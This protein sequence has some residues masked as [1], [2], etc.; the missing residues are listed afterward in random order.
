MKAIVY[1]KYGPP[2]VLQEREVQKPVLK[3]NEV[4]IRNH[5]ATVTLYDCWLRRGTG[6]PGFGLISRIDSGFR[7]PKQPVLGTEFAGEVDAVGA[8]VTQFKPGDAVFG[9]TGI[10]LGAYAEL[11]TM[12]QDGMIALKPDSLTYEEAA[13][14]PYGSLTALFFLSKA[15]IQSGQKALIFGASGGVGT[16][17]VQLAKSMGADVT[18]VCSGNKAEMVKA[19]GADRI[20][21]Y[22]T[23]DFTRR[24]E[25]YDVIF[26]TIGRSPF[27]GS[28][29]SLHKN[30][31][32]L[33]ATFGLTRLLRI[34]WLKF[35]GRRRVGP[36]AAIDENP[37]DL[38]LLKEL[39]ADGKLKPYIDRCFS[40][41]QAAQA[42]R[43]VETGHKRGNVVITVG[44]NDFG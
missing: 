27:S 42:H 21:D 31:I 9:F 14:V 39:V 5:A 15:S 12:P 28:V 37:E 3:D 18:G 40:F 26:D 24:G 10:R 20:I 25:K 41:E 16:A 33:F 4:L 6:P 17:A 38:A 36:L 8:V 30:G 11:I 34:L 23:E 44:Q 7:R 43:Y 13:A 32:Y 19:L 29:R 2:E 35:T 22:T 1:E